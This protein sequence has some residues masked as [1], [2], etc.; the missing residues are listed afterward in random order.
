MVPAVQDFMEGCPPSDLNLLYL[1]LSALIGLFI[2]LAV[3]SVLKIK[4]GQQK[5]V[6]EKSRRA[7]VMD[8]EFQRLQTELYGEKLR[9]LKHQNTSYAASVM[10]VDQAQVEEVRVEL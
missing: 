8:P 2:F 5:H 4:K 7:S 1:I 9:R 10:T 6:M 3:I